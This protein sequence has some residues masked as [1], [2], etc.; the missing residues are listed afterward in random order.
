MRQRPLR[1]QK[2]VVQK[3]GIEV[4]ALESLGPVMLKV[5][6]PDGLLSSVPKD[7]LNLTIIDTKDYER[8]GD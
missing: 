1:G 6:L 5:L 8:L 2:Y 4:T 7:D 3:T